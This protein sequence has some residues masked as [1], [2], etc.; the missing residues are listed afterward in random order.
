[1]D[2]FSP[3]ALGRRM[4]MGSPNRPMNHGPYSGSSGR[5]LAERWL[6]RVLSRLQTIVV[7]FVTICVSAAN[8]TQ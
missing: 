6:T 7:H 3:S 8:V 4:R 2:E 5:A 1:M